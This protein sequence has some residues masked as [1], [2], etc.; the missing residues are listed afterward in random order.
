M[1]IQNDTNELNQ[2]ALENPQP[3]DYWHE[4][5]SPYFMV[6]RVN[7]DEITVLSCM[8]G[9][10]SFKRKDELNAKIENPDGTW[11]FDYSKSMVVNRAWME[12]AVKYGTI[13]GFCADVVRS[14]KYKPVVEEYI[15]YR[16]KALIKE[17]KGLGPEVSRNLLLENW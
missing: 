14:E 2:L 13:D 11:S 1:I 3:G 12:K 7:V 15:E 6:V 9:P 17:L 8:G 5:F 4:M 16:A 10:K